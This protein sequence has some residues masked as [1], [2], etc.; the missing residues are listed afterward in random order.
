MQNIVEQTDTN[1]I[2]QPPPRP[3]PYAALFD[4]INDHLFSQGIRPFLDPL[5]VVGTLALVIGMMVSFSNWILFPIALLVITRV[6]I[7]LSWLYERVWAEIVLLR[8]GIQSHAQLTRLRP[9]RGLH[10]DIDG[11]LLD[12]SIAVTPRRT[13]IG[14]FWVANSTEALRMMRQGHIRVLCLPTAPA[15]WRINEPIDS[16]IRYDRMAPSEE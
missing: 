1:Y 16:E 15:Y 6:G 12:Y 14:S 4:S 8:Y 2:D 13:Y 9:H 10:G 5:T 7:G 11:V 3:M